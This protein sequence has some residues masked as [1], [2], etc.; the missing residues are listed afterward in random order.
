MGGGHLLGDSYIHGEMVDD[1]D[2]DDDDDVSYVRPN[3]DERQ[4]LHDQHMM[5]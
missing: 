5:I 3:D 4:Q 1:D 2:D